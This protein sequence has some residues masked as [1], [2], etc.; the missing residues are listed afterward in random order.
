V[1]ATLASYKQEVTNSL[2]QYQH[3]KEGNDERIR[4]L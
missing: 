3:L 2:S 4:A 1:R